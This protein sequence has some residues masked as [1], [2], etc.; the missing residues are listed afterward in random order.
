MSIKAK[1]LSVIFG[2]II[3]VAAILSFQSVVSIKKISQSDINKYKTEAYRVKENELKNYVSVAL[4]SIDTFYKRGLKNKIK[5]EVQVTLKEHLFQIYSLI[6]EIYKKNKGKISDERIKEKIKFIIANTRYGKSGYFWI[7]DM[8]SNMITHPIK[9]AMNGTNLSKLKDSNGVY[10]INEMVKVCK[11]KG[12]GFVDYKWVKPGYD[13]PQ[14]KVS[15]VKSFKPYNWIIGT[16]AYVD[17]ISSKLQKEALTAISKMRYGK[18]GYYFVL[19]NEGTTLMHSIKPS[20]VGRDLTSLKDI[21]G[22]YFIKDMVKASKTKSKSGLVKYVWEKPGFVKP[23]PKFS[24]IKKFENWNWIVGTGAYVDDIKDKVNLM[25]KEAEEQIKSLIINLIIWLVFILIV[26]MIAANIIANNTIIKP[27][28][29]FEDRL[30]K[31]FKHISNDTQDVLYLDDSSNDEFG[32]MAKTVNKGIKSNIEIQDKMLSLMSTM[33]ENIILSETDENGIITNISQAFC[34]VS[35]YTKDELIGKPHSIVRHPDMP[36]SA[37]E[38]MWQTIQ[39]GKQWDGEVKNLKKDGNSYWVSAII[40]PRFTQDGKICGYTAIRHDITSKK[41]IEQLTTDLENKI[42]RRTKELNNE[43]NLMNSVMNAQK[44]IVLTTN[45]IKML[46][47]NKAFFDFF[48]LNTVEEFGNKYGACICDSFNK[49]VPQGYIKKDMDGVKWVDYILSR[50]DENHKTIISQNNI[51]Y[52][53]AISAEVFT[54]DGNELKAVVFTDIT[55]MEQRNQ[56]IENIMQYSMNEFKSLENTL[57]NIQNGKL[58]STYT[59]KEIQDESLKE[60]NQM[61]ISLGFSIDKLQINLK[62]I[63]KGIGELVVNAQN[64]ELSKRA[65][66]DEFEGGWKDLVSGIN[67]MLEII[68]DAVIKDGVAALVK[69]SQGYIDT[70]MTKEYKG[71]YDTFKQA[72]NTMADK[73]HNIVVETNNSTTQIA[74]A[75][76]SVN[77]TAQTLSTGATQQASSLQETT[78]ALE[79]MSGSISESTQNANKTNLLAEDSA[80][81]SMTGG[82][83]VNKTVTAMQTIA[84]RIK[85]IED[86]VYQTNLLA[87]NAAIEAARAGEHGKGFAVVAAEVRKLA[88]RSQ[89]AASEISDITTNSLSIS[90][91]AGEL[92]SKVVPQIQETSTLIKD[93]AVSSSEQNIGISQITQSMNQLDQV[94][95]T[96]AIGSQ[97][98]ATTSEELDAQITS[99]ATIMEFFKFNKDEVSQVQ[100]QS[101]VLDESKQ[102]FKRKSVYKS[103]KVSNKKD[104]N[105]DDLDLRE[106]DRY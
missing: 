23:Q 100:G 52:V 87:L 97:E 41:E 18:S 85:I 44:N 56:E 76:Q 43:K 101:V 77:T 22:V 25:K 39:S 28:K 13:K 38:N 45:G 4:S 58:D 29:R 62:N 106:F 11:D 42:E 88:K 1:L 83:A 47:N 50:P 7:N 71:D 37:F 93:I 17:G 73:I 26:V 32:V 99:L 95:Q 60:T 70:R 61:F 30:L 46:G 74:K 5:E 105:H 9:P 67:Q 36:K 34:K 103:Q 57:I 86:I 19:D 79:Q 54:V 48:N 104:E 10:I 20:L 98:L 16:G 84:D 53:F 66:L 49:E 27:L 89:V 15:F 24:Y 2:A 90:Q 6:N 80:K 59:P 55:K 40:T 14:S 94:T 35:G 21:N 33:D 82:S 65:S 63:E 91:E 75:S 31:F 81:M 92:I 51:D 8:H 69:L 72:V 68:S 64:G 12:E 78:S 96:N 3:I 102:E